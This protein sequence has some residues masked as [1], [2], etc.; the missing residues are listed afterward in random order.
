MQISRRDIMNLE[1]RPTPSPLSAD[2]DKV[3]F[4]RYGIEVLQLAFSPLRNDNYKAL[5][6]L[7]WQSR[8]LR[9]PIVWSG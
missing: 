7:I 9:N 4:F 5:K 2:A 3:L 6:N 8:Y 1:C